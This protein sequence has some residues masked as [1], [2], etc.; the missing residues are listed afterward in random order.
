MNTPKTI[1]SG[2]IS[3]ELPYKY[4]GDTRMRQYMG[5][6]AVIITALS[7][8]WGLFQLYVSSFGVLDAIILRSW[9]IIFL[10]VMVFLLFPAGKKPAYSLH[11]PTWW[12]CICLLAGAASFGY[13]ILNYSEIALRGGY[14]L[15]LDYL[16]AVLGI[17]IVFEAARR[18]VR[19]LAILAAVFLLYNFAGS[20]L[21]GI[22]GHVGFSWKRIVEHLFWGGQGLLGIGAGVSAT[23]VFMFILFGSFL[24][25]SGFSR[26]IN[27]L[28]LTIAGRSPGGPAKVSVI[29]SSLMGMVNG[30]ALANVATTGSITIP[31]MIKNGY[32]RK[33]AAAVEAA[34]STGGQ[35][36]PPIMG[37]AGFIMAEFLG[38]PYTTVMLAAVVPA[39][40]YF[41]TLIMAVHFEARK[42]GLKGISKENI[43]KVK[44]VLKEEGHLSIPL[45]TLIV[46]L[47][48]GYTPLYAAVFS[49]I[50]TVLASWLRRK[51]RMG[52]KEI[53]QAFEEGAK[54]AVSV[55]VACV[56]IG[57]IVGTVSLTGLG[58]SFGY[59]I[60]KFAGDQLFLAALFVMILSIILG[61]GVPGVAAYVIVAAVA[62]PVL[63]ELE[64]PAIAAHMFVLIYACLSN[65]TPPVALS[66]YIAAGIANADQT[67]TSLVALR[68]GLTGFIMPFMFIYHPEILLR[69]EHITESMIP[70]IT[71]TIGVL[72]LAGASQGWLL[73]QTTHAQRL[74]LLLA[75]FCL[76]EPSFLFDIAGVVL[77]VVVLALQIYQKNNFQLK[78]EQFDQVP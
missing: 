26:F 75:A 31:M 57:V 21:P 17:L 12:D 59:G 54:S 53:I 39:F 64:V 10:L 28:A 6:M 77:F 35:F 34:A 55:G 61:M 30:S 72:S 23:F 8:I 3:E 73:K 13:L 37:A 68:L 60:L 16:F 65:I 19:S 33:F 32:K 27:N 49:I 45:V 66:S 9:H 43:P 78:D 63:I 50:A 40:L 41:L 1:N 11:R 20:Y 29:A 5:I 42:T 38:V 7:V 36:A 25:I 51:T 58:L 67:Q 76:I 71:A 74:V 22:L 62:A 44:Q 48:L 69:S 47:L 56:I 15:P 18:T 2:E 70:I 52:L 24:K 46:L 4:E 14:L